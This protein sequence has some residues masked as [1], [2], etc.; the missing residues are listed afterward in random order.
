MKL[1]TFGIIASLLSYTYSQGCTSD[2]QVRC[3]N[4]IEKGFVFK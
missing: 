4:D 1:I 2:L 3:L